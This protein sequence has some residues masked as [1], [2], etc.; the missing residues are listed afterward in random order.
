[1]TDEATE[2]TD[3][4]TGRTALADVLADTPIDPDDGGGPTFD[5]PWQARAFGVAV[6]LCEREAFDLSTF[7]AR[8]AQRIDELDA[9]SMQEDVEGTYY[10]QWLDCLEDVLLEAGVVDDAELAARAAEFTDGD[11]DAA[12]FVVDDPATVDDPTAA[13]DSTAADDPTGDQS[14]AGESGQ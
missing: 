2:G 13:D 9:E 5:A 1:M 10:E 7:Q 12:E 14:S 11:R 8:F 6:A 4:A 3:E